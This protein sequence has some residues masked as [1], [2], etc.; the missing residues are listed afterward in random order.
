M[1]SCPV[2]AS[3]TAAVTAVEALPVLTGLGAEAVLEE[4]VPVLASAVA[5]L[6]REL[7]VRMA[8][9]ERAATGA[10]DVRGAAVR[11][12]LDP[13]RAGL[14]RRVGVFTDSHRDVDRGWRTG[15]V[16]LEQI[17]LLRRGAGKELVKS[18]V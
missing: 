14:L 8:A 16:R 3:L 10:S 9:L 17:E 7:A 1:M 18:S 11:A 6:Q 15:Q 5:R 2:L 4:Q 13:R 12:G